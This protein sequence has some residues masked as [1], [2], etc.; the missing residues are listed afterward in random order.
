MTD[1][2]LLNILPPQVRAEVNNVYASLVSKMFASLERLAAGDA[3]HGERLRLENYAFFL[4]SVR[5]LV[6]PLAVLQPFHK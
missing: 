5:P 6:R 4:E 1:P 3:K 2:A